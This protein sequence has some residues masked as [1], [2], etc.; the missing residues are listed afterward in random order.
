M[1]LPFIIVAA[2]ANGSV[3]AVRMTG[4]GPPE[5]LAAHSQDG[6]FRVPMTFMVLDQENNAARVTVSAERLTWH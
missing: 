3:L 5:T 1:A 4:D 6:G 2:S